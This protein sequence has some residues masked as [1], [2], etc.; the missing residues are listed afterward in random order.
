MPRRGSEG[1]FV[2][3]TISSIKRRGFRMPL[4]I[5]FLEFVSDPDQDI[6]GSSVPEKI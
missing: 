2:C 4:D 1:A 5:S 6:E 3:Y